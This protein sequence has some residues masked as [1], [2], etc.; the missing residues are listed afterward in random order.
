MLSAQNP[1]MPSRL[2]VWPNL[3]CPGNFCE[4]AQI[5]RCCNTE[6][7]LG[8]IDNPFIERLEG[9]RTGGQLIA[10]LFGFETRRGSHTIRPGSW[11]I[12][13]LI[14]LLTTLFRQV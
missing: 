9:P 8:V 13:T 5:N 2:H 12:V 1:S 10:R 4:D 3:E 6:V 7:V 14:K 11:R